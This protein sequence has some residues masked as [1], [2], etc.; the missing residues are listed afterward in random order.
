MTYLLPILLKH[1]HS[2]TASEKAAKLFTS[3]SI[4]CAKSLS[5]ALIYSSTFEADF[6]PRCSATGTQ[7][8]VL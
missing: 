4:N 2:Y 3:K 1:V 7:V 5:Y 6:M 8:K